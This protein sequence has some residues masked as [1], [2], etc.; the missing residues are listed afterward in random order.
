MQVPQNT[1]SC[2]Q[3]ALVPVQAGEFHLGGGSQVLGLAG[4]VEPGENVNQVLSGLTIHSNLEF[5]FCFQSSTGQPQHPH[6]QVRNVPGE[7]V[8]HLLAGEGSHQ[9]QAD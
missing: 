1:D 6:Q 4:Q 5:L 2:Y 9:A 3:V 8:P 7:Q